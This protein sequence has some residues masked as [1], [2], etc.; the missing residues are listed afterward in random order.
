[1]G[2]KG[3]GVGEAQQEVGV[4]YCPGWGSACSLEPP[5]PQVWGSLSPLALGPPVPGV[6]VELQHLSGVP[7]SVGHMEGRGPMAVTVP[8]TCCPSSQT[9]SKTREG[10]Q[11]L[12]PPCSVPGIPAWLL[13]ACNPLPTV[14]R[15]SPP[16]CLLQ[17][18]S[19]CA[20]EA[21]IS[22]SFLGEF[23]SH[24]G[25]EKGPLL[26]TQPSQPIVFPATWAPSRRFVHPSVPV[27][28]ACRPS[29]LVFKRQEF[30]PETSYGHHISSFLSQQPQW[31]LLHPRTQVGP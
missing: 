26:T 28:V 30:S 12:Q 16:T 27:C 5:P 22:T 20:W 2:V 4:A 17:E 8:E 31:A 29:A 10:V 25:R 9:L 6:F 15:V 13:S 18:T 3:G 7:G 1:M 23:P 14:P 21:D 24:S 11:G 19:R